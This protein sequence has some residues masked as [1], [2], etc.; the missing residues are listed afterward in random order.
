MSFEERLRQ[1]R[2]PLEK[3]LLVVSELTRRLKPKGITPIV[4]GGSAVEIYSAGDYLS[5]DIDLVVASRQQAVAELQQMGFRAEGRVFYHPK[6]DITLEIPDETLAGDAERITEIQVDNGVVYC[7]GL[8]D[9]ILD[10]LNAF[11]YWRSEE[12]GRWARVLL[13]AYATEIDSDYLKVRAEQESTRAALETMLQEI[14]DATPMGLDNS[15]P[16]E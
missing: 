1:A 6:W 7:I 15:E 14:A 9:L 4:V 8:E 5:A 3:K 11:V 10:R 12:D 13:Q 16:A 2:S